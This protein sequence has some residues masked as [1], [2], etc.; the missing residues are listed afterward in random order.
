MKFYIALAAA[1]TVGSAIA[2]AADSAATDSAAAPAAGTKHGACAAD[3]QKF[4]ANVE[5]GKGKMH[6]CL[7][8]HTADLSDGCK[9]RMAEHALKSTA[10]PPA[11]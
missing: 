3:I 9:Q 4:C 10:T 11:N 5:H 6:E 2:Y 7:T 1:L 8:Q